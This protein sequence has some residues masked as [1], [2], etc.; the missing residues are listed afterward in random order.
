M[1]PDQPIHQLKFNFINW[2]S[3]LEKWNWL[4]IGYFRLEFKLNWNW[5]NYFLICVEVELIINPTNM[6]KL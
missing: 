2:N 6:T 1:Q 3:N 4:K 5:I